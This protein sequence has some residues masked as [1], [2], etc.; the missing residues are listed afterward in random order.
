MKLNEFLKLNDL[1]LKIFVCSNNEYR[2]G[3]SPL[4]EIKDSIFLRSECGNS[5]KDIK[6]A[7]ENTLKNIS[8]KTLKINNERYIEVL[9]IEL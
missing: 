6:I 5:N 3:F 1:S 2:V 7:I 8:N 9:D 4:V